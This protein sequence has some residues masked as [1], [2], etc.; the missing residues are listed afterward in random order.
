[1]RQILLATFALLLL[2]GCKTSGYNPLKIESQQWRLPAG[3]ERLLTSL[4][5][6]ARRGF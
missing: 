3:I 1:M 5:G 6:H 4:M 2:A